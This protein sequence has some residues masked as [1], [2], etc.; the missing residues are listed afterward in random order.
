MNFLKE[1]DWDVQ[2]RTEVARILDP[3]LAKSKFL[4]AEE[5]A[6][7]Q[8]KNHLSARY[9]TVEIF[10]Q[11]HND[12]D[13]DE[14]DKFI[15]MIVI[16]IALYHLWSKESPNNIPK[17]RELRYADAIKWL[18]AVQSGK[19]CNLPLI[20]D[21]KGEPSYDVRIWSQHKPEDNRY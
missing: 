1:T 4:T 5:M 18:E 17:T 10:K 13:D 2:V 9:N 8:I 15:V 6:I 16:D 20:T 12:S 19:P 3:T 14:R 21:A 11:A 7:S